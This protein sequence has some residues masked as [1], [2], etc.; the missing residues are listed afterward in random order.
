MAKKFQVPPK[1]KV[2]LAVGLM[3][4]VAFFTARATVNRLS[5]PRPASAPL[6]APPI[7]V[8]PKPLV[9]PSAPKPAAGARLAI[10]LDDWGNKPALVADAIAVG[11]PLT[12]SILPDHKFT[13]RIAEEAHAAGLGVMLHL[14]MQPKDTKQPREPLGIYTTT[15]D[16]EIRRVVSTSLS[17]VPHAEGINNH[18]GSAAT[19]DWRVMRAVM[20][21]VKRRGVFFVDSIVI[22]STVGPSVARETGTRFNKRDVFLDNKNEIEPIKEELRR[23][24]RLAL[25]HGSAIAIGHDR[26]LTLQAIREM[27]PELERAGVRLV[28][29]RDLIR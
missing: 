9:A 29:A 11:R 25:Q 20:G 3:L 14:P 7:A 17:K 2:A 16:D 13:K 6:V 1:L 26:K 8:A 19:S 12:L 22:G 27:I 4:A 23:A 18:Q 15:S 5:P 21:E 28:L 24:A 10:I